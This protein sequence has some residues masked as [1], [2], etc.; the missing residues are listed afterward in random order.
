[1]SLTSAV[2]GRPAAAATRTRLPASARAS[3]TS[4]MNAPWPVF[5]SSTSART[6]AASFFERMLAVIS[7]TDSTVAVTSRIA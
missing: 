2:A 6:P 3:A 4:L 7:G 1:M 5:T